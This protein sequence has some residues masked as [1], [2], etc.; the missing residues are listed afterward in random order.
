MEKPEEKQYR[1]TWTIDEYASSP[2]EAVLKALK[3]MPT[4]EESIATFFE[5]LEIVKG[6]LEN[7]EEIDLLELD[8]N[9]I[10]E[11]KELGNPIAQRFLEV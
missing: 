5:T 1:V 4:N 7:P 8:E 10:K 2:L 3:H 6:K 11:L 9:Q